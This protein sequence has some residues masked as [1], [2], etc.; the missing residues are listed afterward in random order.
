ML[1]CVWLKFCIYNR[2]MKA[3]YVNVIFHKKASKHF[4]SVLSYSFEILHKLESFDFCC[5]QYLILPLIFSSR[6]PE[7]FETSYMSAANW[8]SVYKWNLYDKG[9]LRQLKA[10]SCPHPSP[11]KCFQLWQPAVGTAP[12]CLLVIIPLY[13]RALSPAVGRHRI[14]RESEFVCSFMPVNICALSCY[15]LGHSCP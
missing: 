14:C 3:V 4:P 15:V 11:W 12:R 7:D 13:S 9:S 6:P 2:D 8:M 5:L 1:T 10:F